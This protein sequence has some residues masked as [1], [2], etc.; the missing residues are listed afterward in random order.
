MKLAGRAALLALG[1][2]LAGCDRVEF[3]PRVLPEAA[4]GRSYRAEV[5]VT[6][7]K[8]A[9]DGIALG[10]GELPAGLTFRFDRPSSRAVIEGTPTT[11][12][13]YTFQLGVWF[14]PARS[15]GASHVRDYVLYVR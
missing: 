1:L 9:V 8:S 6:G 15:P 11:T 3:T 4:V 12:G 10:S 13:T 14:A 7:G 2:A 5:G